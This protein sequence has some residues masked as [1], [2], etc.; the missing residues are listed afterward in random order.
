M[1]MTSHIRLPRTREL[2]HFFLCM[3]QPSISKGDCPITWA[4]QRRGVEV[5]GGLVLH[6]ETHIFRNT[7]TGSLEESS[8]GPL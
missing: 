4:M 2:G 7:G 5:A 6:L 1:Q 8:F 3:Q